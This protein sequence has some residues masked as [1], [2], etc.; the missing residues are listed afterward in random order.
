MT[1]DDNYDQALKCSSQK[2]SREGEGERARERSRLY[3]RT[4]GFADEME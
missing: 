3:Q 2:A 1:R 4:R